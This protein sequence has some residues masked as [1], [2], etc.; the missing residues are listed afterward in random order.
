MKMTLISSG[1]FTENYHVVAEEGEN[2]TVEQLTEKFDRP[3]GC[4]VTGGN[5]HFN[6]TI[7]TD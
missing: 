3:F 2:L 5:G 4:H 6:V 7:Y 1:I